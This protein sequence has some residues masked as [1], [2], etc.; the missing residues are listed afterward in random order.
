MKMYT[1]R[2]V[3]PLTDITKH[4]RRCVDLAYSAALNSDFDTFR[5]GAC[6]KHIKV[7]FQWIQ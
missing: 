1:I 2:T 3:T 7:S 4:D 5:V 6:L